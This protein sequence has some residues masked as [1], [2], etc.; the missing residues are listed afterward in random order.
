MGTSSS[1]LKMSLDTQDYH[2]VQLFGMPKYIVKCLAMDPLANVIYW[3][4]Y[5]HERVARSVTETIR[6]LDL[7]RNQP[8]TIE[9]ILENADEVPQDLAVDWSSGNLYWAPV[10]LSTFDKITAVKVDPIRGYL[11]YCAD[12]RL[13][14]S[15]LDGVSQRLVLLNLTSSHFCQLAFDEATG[16]ILLPAGRW[17]PFRSPAKVYAAFRGHLYWLSTSGDMSLG[18]VDRNGSNTRQPVPPARQRRLRA[19]VHPQAG[20]H[21]LWPVANRRICR[22]PSRFRFAGTRPPVRPAASPAGAGGRAQPVP[23]SEAPSW[24]SASARDIGMAPLNLA[25][26]FGIFARL[27]VAAPCPTISNLWNLPPDPSR[28]AICWADVGRHIALR[29]AWTPAGTLGADTGGRAVAP[30]LS[31]P[32]VTQPLGLAVDWATNLLF[33]IDKWPWPR[34]SLNSRRIHAGSRVSPVSPWRIRCANRRRVRIIGLGRAVPAR[35]RVRP[36]QSDPVR[37]GPRPGR[38]M[39]AMRLRTRGISALRNSSGGESPCACSDLHRRAPWLTAGGFTEAV[40][41]RGD[42]YRLLTGWSRG[43]HQLHLQASSAM[44]K[45]S[46]LHWLIRRTAGLEACRP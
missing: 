36:I 31:V 6:R 26:R 21:P 29:P 37:H 41:N 9:K 11:F 25:G 40:R 32:A 20:P 39:L 17:Q 16:D 7:T 4:D 35:I 15:R 28:A 10:R 23:G 19:A 38:P 1:V 33:Y 5:L 22:W 27:R 46:A 2:P 12:G 14:R 34:G 18:I 8:G 44:L 13:V 3:I 43:C 45:A 24:C 30:G 42:R